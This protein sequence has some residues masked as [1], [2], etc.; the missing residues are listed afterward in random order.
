MKQ[1]D[2]ED[3]MVRTSYVEV[4]GRR[5]PHRGGSRR[6]SGVVRLMFLAG[7][8]AG[9]ASAFVGLGG[10]SSGVRARSVALQAIVREDGTVILDVT[11]AYTEDQAKEEYIKVLNT[12]ITT[13]ASLSDMYSGN[14]VGGVSMPATYTE[15]TIGAYDSAIRMYT[16]LP[17]I[18]PE[19]VGNVGGVVG[20]VQEEVRSCAKRYKASRLA[21][22]IGISAL[23]ITAAILTGF[24]GPWWTIALAIALTMGAVSLEV[25]DALLE[26]TSDSRVKYMLNVAPEICGD[27]S[28]PTIGPG[29]MNMLN[30]TTSMSAVG[31]PEDTGLVALFDA[32]NGATVLTPDGL[33]AWLTLMG[34]YGS[35]PLD[36]KVEIYGLIADAAL[37]NSVEES[38]EAVALLADM[39]GGGRTMLITKAILEGF[40]GASVALGLAQLNKLTFMRTATV[41][42]GI[43]LEVLGEEA[44]ISK[45]GVLSRMAN[46][47]L[48]SKKVAA[49]SAALGTIAISTITAIDAVET[50]RSIDE[51]RDTSVAAANNTG[52]MCE[53]LI[54]LSTFVNPVR[55]YTMGS[56][57]VQP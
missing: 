20:G 30:V 7:V 40:G 49:T 31:L 3:N 5:L 21:D 33:N 13:C 32:C 1:G 36:E 18:T 47:I 56:K 27:P 15:T 28:L 51:M 24:F 29:V 50:S 2:R 23:T 52:V 11:R 37:A 25:R 38:E 44:V 4:T 45:P 53:T 8:S 9:P 46:W 39:I 43:E 26:A 12:Y 22:E 54:T 41:D 17:Q 57:W 42:V 19:E 34:E 48:A 55:D 10:L 35:R 16:A 6:S 14:P